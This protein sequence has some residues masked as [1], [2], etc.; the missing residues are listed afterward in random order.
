MINYNQTEKENNL[1]TTLIDLRL[2]MGSLI[3]INTKSVS[4]WWGLYVLSN[5]Q[6]TLKV[7]FVKRLRAL[8]LGWKKIV[9]YKT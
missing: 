1:D 2:D 9:A 8:R 7:Q 4:V 6:P 3:L 5:T